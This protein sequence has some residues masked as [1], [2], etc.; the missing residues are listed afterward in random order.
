M[1]ARHL[2]I[3]A[4]PPSLV[5]FANLLKLQ[6]LIIQIVNEGV[7]LDQPAAEVILHLAHQHCCG[8]EEPASHIS[9]CLPHRA[10]LVVCLESGRACQEID[11]ALRNVG[12]VLGIIIC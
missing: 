9:L 10:G 5:S 12:S 11:S 4:T 6:C 8:S 7:E 3:A 2:G 1:A